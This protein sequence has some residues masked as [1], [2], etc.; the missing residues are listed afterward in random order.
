MKFSI[1]FV[2]LLAVSCGKI[3]TSG[4]AG[5]GGVR[6]LVPVAISTSD[7]VTYDRICAALTA[8]D[9][10]LNSSLP[11]SLVF[12][13][14]EKDCDGD[15]VTFN[16]QQVRVEASGAGFQFRR[17]DTNALFLYPNVETSDAGFMK[18]ICDG[19]AKSLPFL[20]GSSEAVWVS[21]SGFSTTDCPN[22]G[23]EQCMVVEYGTKQGTT[24]TYVIHTVEYVRFNLLSTSGKYGY[25]THRKSLATNN[26]DQGENT[27]SEAKLR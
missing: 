23:N 21:P 8:K 6:E 5:V 27:E 10:K 25:F 13:V 7:A 1:L 26:C 19:T 2:A 12:D 14:V 18:E 16:T 17:Q 22:A 4:T 24:N 11:N 9:S 3:T 20:R 15:T